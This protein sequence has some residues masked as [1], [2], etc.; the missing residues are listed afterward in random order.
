MWRESDALFTESRELPQKSSVAVLT[1]ADKCFL[2]ALALFTVT[3][4]AH[5][6]SR[7]VHRQWDECQTTIPLAKH[8]YCVNIT[9]VLEH[10]RRDATNP[11]R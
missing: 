4:I 6:I 2:A 11:S 8:Q 5:F 9:K 3:I 7:D 1:R 10:R